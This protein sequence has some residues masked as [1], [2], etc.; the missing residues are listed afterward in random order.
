MWFI[1]SIADPLLTHVND[2]DFRAVCTVGMKLSPRIAIVWNRCKAKVDNLLGN[3]AEPEI[4]TTDGSTRPTLPIRPFP[5]PFPYD[6]VEIIIAHLIHH[7]RTLKAC[8]L[9][10]R[11]LY[12]AAVPHL[13]RTVTLTGGRPEID[14]SRL[15]PLSKLHELGLTSFAREIRV[16]QGPGPS[17]WFV[18]QAFGHLD[19]HY[20]SAFTNVHTLKLENI[21]IHHFLPHIEHYF[22]HFSPTLQSITLY[23][24]RCSPQQL[25]RF[26]SFFPNLDDIIIRISHTHRLDTTAP[27]TELV[28]FSTPK[29]R[30]TL[31]LYNFPW[32][33]TWTHMIA[34]CGG[35]RFHH[36]DLRKNAS[37]GPLLLEA[38]AD[39]LEMLRFDAT[40]GP[41]ST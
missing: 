29:L 19:L 10:C 26:L 40:D 5:S 30:G 28:P 39:T 41:V 21:Q 34:S 8:S 27:D 17:P 24:P 11:S 1:S 38:C 22:G 15:R 3:T 4:C 13:H 16:K 36:L 9:S 14:R 23:D 31:V 25:F 2:P 7:R 12:T 33:E 6:I 32:V 20:F 37:Y 18:P 35:L